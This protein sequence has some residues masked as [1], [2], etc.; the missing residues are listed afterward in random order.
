MR[1]LVDEDVQTCLVFYLEDWGHSAAHVKYRAD[2]VEED[3]PVVLA[4]AVREG[5]VIVTYNVTDYEDLHRQYQAAAQHHLGIIVSR[6]QRAA[7]FRN[8][9][10]WMGNLLRALSASDLAD[11]VHY[12]HTFT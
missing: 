6:Q 5:R 11:Q 12:L 4:A 10:R 3:D 2:L 1:F 8:T 7:S 9:L